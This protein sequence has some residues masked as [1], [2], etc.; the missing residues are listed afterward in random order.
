MRKDIRD[1]RA[2]VVQ[3]RYLRAR[4]TEVDAQASLKKYMRMS[5]VDPLALLSIKAGDLK[6]RIKTEEVRYGIF[7]NWVKVLGASGRLSREPYRNWLAAGRPEMK[8]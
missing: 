7:R 6:N 4:E 3:Y 5:G 1:I 8:P 2:L